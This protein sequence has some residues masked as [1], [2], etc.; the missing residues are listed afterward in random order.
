MTCIIYIQG[1]LWYINLCVSSILGGLNQSEGIDA[2]AIESFARVLSKTVG[3][4]GT[5]ILIEP[6]TKDDRAFLKQLEAYISCEKIA[7]QVQEPVSMVAGL[8]IT[9]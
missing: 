5:V 1:Y 2:Q 4:Q 7:D 8:S 9:S 3:E 6:G